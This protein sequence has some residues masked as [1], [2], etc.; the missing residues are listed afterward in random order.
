MDNRP[1]LDSFPY[2]FPSVPTTNDPIAEVISDRLMNA[3]AAKWF[4]AHPAQ[5]MMIM[6][7]SSR[8]NSGC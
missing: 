3:F 4:D 1:T 7:G 5:A 8:A 2:K 6:I